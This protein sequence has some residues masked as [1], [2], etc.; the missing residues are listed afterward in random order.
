MG[1]MD[2]E[3][4][5]SATEADIARWKQEDGIDDALLGPPRFVTSV[6]NDPQA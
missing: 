4:L 1:R 2:V 5:K 3:R 6:R